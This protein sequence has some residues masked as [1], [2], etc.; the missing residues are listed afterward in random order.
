MDNQI[1]QK[2]L[3]EYVSQAVRQ[4]NGT[5]ADIYDCL[6]QIT[7][8]GW[9]TRHKDEK[10][11]A[12]QDAMRAFDGLP[13][14]EGGVRG[15][16]PGGEREPTQSAGEEHQPDLAGGREDQRALHVGLREPREPAVD[17]SEQSEQAKQAQQRWR[18][19]E[20]R[21][22]AQH[23]VDAG[24]D[25][26]RAIEDGRGRRRSF[27]RAGDPGRERYL[28]RLGQRR[29]HEAQRQQTGGER[30]KMVG[31]QQ[32]GPFHAAEPDEGE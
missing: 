31:M 17:G 26:Q 20:G 28:R 27:Q 21:R 23:Q 32:A 1:Y 15:E 16:V 8:G 2:Y 5:V 18:V 6:G 9:L 19:L 4:S 14:A 30:T 25:H 10:K 29:H 12:L 13:G 22:E 7:V 24:M 3:H 11:R